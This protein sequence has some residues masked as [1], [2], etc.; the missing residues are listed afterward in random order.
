MMKYKYINTTILIISLMMFFSCEKEDEITNNKATVD[1]KS[2]LRFPH[3]VQVVNGR[4]EFD[5]KQEFK[6]NLNYLL[7]KDL[8]KEDL[9]TLFD[10]FYLN[11]F[12]PLYPHFPIDDEQKLSE[13][14]DIRIESTPESRIDSTN[15]ELTD[16]L[17]PINEF[18]SL[19]N[20]K[21]EIVIDEKL[22]VYTYSGLYIADIRKQE[23]LYQ[24]LENNNIY[25]EAP[26]PFSLQT[27]L[28]NVQSGIDVYVSNN[29]MPNS[30]S[31]EF[32]NPYEYESPF[33]NLTQYP[34]AS[35]FCGSGGG[36]TN[37]PDDNETEDYTNEL[38]G[39]MNQLESC[40]QIDVYTPF[41]TIKKCFDWF[42]NGN[43]RTKTKYEHIDLGVP[44]FGDI[45]QS[46]T[47]KVKHQKEYDLWFISYWGATETDEVALVINQ[48][49]FLIDPP[50]LG[51]PMSNFNYPQ[52]DGGISNAIY[53]V[54]EHGYN[55]NPNSTLAYTTETSLPD[56]TPITPFNEDVIVQ[57]YN[58][59]IPTLPLVDLSTTAEQINDIYWDTLHGQAKSIFKQLSGYDPEKIT[60][61]YHT[62]DQILVHHV[63][64]SKR[65]Y[66]TKKI[67]DNLYFD[68]AAN[69]V[70][71]ISVD[72][73]NNNIVTN[74]DN[75]SD[76]S[77]GGN[78]IFSYSVEK[79]SLADFDR[80]YVD[81]DGLT[82]RNETWRGSKMIYEMS[83]N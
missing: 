79:Q 39:Y 12:T 52:D 26:D 7:N 67:V 14:L 55:Y 13:S 36:G 22:Y 19:L 29:L 27:G 82:R 3:E 44:M 66:N 40:A 71:T 9:N 62:D 32:D 16:Q 10:S 25:N 49:T 6:G 45:L 28:N 56:L 65:V 5:T 58:N 75:L 18:A 47:V 81:F 46:I 20:A 69:F 73:W 15:L 54:D 74:P 43:R 38:I 53:Y 24:Y 77:S 72:E 42:P 48:A 21:R 8:S 59:N 57:V 4:L 11:G 31:C 80:I 1:A 68:L 17:V 61:I 51:V 64:I 78:D 30:V 37:P 70:V 83:P 41:G 63:D 50:S 33:N 76:E 23:D 2:N 34:G 60:T 35:S